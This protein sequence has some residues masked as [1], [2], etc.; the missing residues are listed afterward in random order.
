[1]ARFASAGRTAARQRPK[2]G[3]RT[4]AAIART[5]PRRRVAS[6]SVAAT[7]APAATV[8]AGRRFLARVDMLLDLELELVGVDLH[9][10]LGKIAALPRLWRLHRRAAG[11]G[12]RR[13]ENERTQR[14]A[15]VMLPEKSCD[16]RPGRSARI[17]SSNTA[18]C[19]SR[20]PLSTATTLPPESIR[21][22]LGIPL[23]AYASGVLPASS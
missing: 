5:S 15:H 11:R 14:M 16:H 3:S 20:N 12:Q 13:H 6:Q 1:G 7:P 19:S 18:F 22:E 21:Y 2:S 17:R 9:R 4:A 23:T 10:S 8:A